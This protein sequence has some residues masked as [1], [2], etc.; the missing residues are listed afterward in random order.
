MAGIP[1]QDRPRS[2]LLAQ[3]LSQMH[4]QSQYQPQS[5]GAL[6]AGLGAQA[7]NQYGLNK[8]TSRLDQEKA[9]Q[10]NY[11]SQ[12]L[13]Q[14]KGG[15]TG[16]VIGDVDGGPGT[17]LQAQYMPDP[18]GASRHM[19]SYLSSGGDPEMALRLTESVEGR[20]ADERKRREELAMF[21]QQMKSQQDALKA[22]LA[23]DEKLT[24]MREQGDTDRLNRQLAL[25][26]RLALLKLQ[27]DSAGNEAERNAA[28][29]KISMDL[30]KEFRGLQ[31]VKD[32]ETAIPRIKAAQSAPDNGFGDLQLIYNVGKLLDPNSVVREGE[33]ALTIAA[34]SPIQRI[35]GT[36][37]FSIDGGGRLTPQARK[38]IV[39]ML[40]GVVGEYQNSYNRD[41]DQYASYAQES[42]LDP[43]KVVGKR[44]VYESP[45]KGGDIF[46]QAD[47]I[48]KGGR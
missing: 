42:G 45:K 32:F 31:P 5:W 29:G 39:G 9:K 26:E 15:P 27:A 4:Q 37:R 17:P 19:G 41:Y 38:Q 12:Y 13:S 6:A 21:Q 1:F 7:I 2:A 11:L 3:I 28:A 46:S 24:A 18:Q 44:I 16:T 22:N 34:N 47:A 8:E 35:L 30:R 33:L 48:L 40:E 43:E 20:A 10:A 36:S 23:S 25:E 14:A